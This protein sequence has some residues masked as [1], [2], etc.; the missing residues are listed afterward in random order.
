MS[1]LNFIQLL[2]MDYLKKLSYG[3]ERRFTD[4]K[5]KLD[6]ELQNQTADV[7]MTEIK[8]VGSVINN[9]IKK[10]HSINLLNTKDQEVSEDYE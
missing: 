5:S 3:E 4:D 10:T 9:K 7:S 2:E 8:E 1:Q 6:I